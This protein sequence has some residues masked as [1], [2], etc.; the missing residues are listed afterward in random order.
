[1]SARPDDH[2]DPVARHYVKGAVIAGT[3][4]GVLLSVGVVPMLNS[5]SRIRE[6]RHRSGIEGSYV[7]TFLSG[8]QDF[9]GLRVMRAQ[10]NEIVAD[11]TARRSTDFQIPLAPW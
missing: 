6:P 9:P 8:T 4:I 1:M 2:T 11:V 7:R 10:E 5:R 3:V